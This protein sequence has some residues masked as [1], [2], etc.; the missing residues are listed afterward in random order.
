MQH[1]NPSYKGKFITLIIID[2]V[3]LT[4]CSQ[5][6]MLDSCPV[7]GAIKYSVINL[8][9]IVIYILSCIKRQ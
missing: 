4:G 6:K 1:D 5:S 8:L 3:V 7:G 9:A 2:I